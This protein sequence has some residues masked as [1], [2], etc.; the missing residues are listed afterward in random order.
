MSYRSRARLRQN[1]KLKSDSTC[2]LAGL[3]SIGIITGAGPF[4]YSR[5]LRPG[6]FSMA[7]FFC[8]IPLFLA[9]TFANLAAQES[10][11]SSF[12]IS[13]TAKGDTQATAKPIYV[14]LWFDTEDYIL[15]A[16]DDAALRLANFLKAE[17]IRGTFKLVGEK[18]K[19]LK[20]RGRTD[21]IE[22]LKYHDIGYHS[23][24]H[25]IPPSPAMYLNALGFEEGVREFR[26]REGKGRQSVHEVFG[27]W[28]SCYGQPGSSWGP[29][30]YPVLRD[31][32][33]IYLDAGKHVSIDGKPCRMGGVL[34][35]YQLEHTIRADLKTQNGMEEGTA[36]FSA[37]RDKL[38]A[39]GGGIVS[40]VYHPCEFI[41]KEFWDG[42]NFRKGASPDRKD[43]KLP[44]TKTPEEA[45][46]AWRNFEGFVRHMKRFP[47]VRFVTAREISAHYPDIA[48]SRTWERS[49]IA[50][51]ISSMGNDP[52]WVRTNDGA[53][54]PAELFDLAI[55]ASLDRFANIT[56]SHKLRTDLA[57]P[58]TASPN[59][60]EKPF[61]AP[62][63]LV[64]EALVQVGEQ[65]E[66]NGQIPPAVWLGS[67]AISPES[68]F[69]GLR[70]A[71]EKAP[72]K[73][74]FAEG[75]WEFPLA[76]LKAAD[77]IEPDEGRL[78]NWVIFP[79]GFRAPNLMSHA[80]RQA[81]TLKPADL[82]REK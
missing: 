40:I 81:W 65:L 67:T 76:R 23:T 55:K 53:L 21:V 19:V 64:R 33:M 60:L 8:L 34:N 3:G 17:G 15:P 62:A 66:Q 54:S 31:W 73:G 35:L 26:R 48:K 45:A 38:L 11:K 72:V 5:R 59:P 44:S 74:P 27:V 63:Y 58:S 28:P 56:R 32:D 78:W 6:N 2:V 82:V 79:E 42:V 80:R 39:E 20:E 13:K 10:P 7:R 37:A 1:N 71:W 14:L 24:N 25:S 18:A 36:K 46:L 49:Q 51:A 70:K 30:S 57:G 61:M 68:F 47:E 29:Q 43:W 77:A 4:F 22:A 75:D 12:A 9:G 16:S 52:T 50:L 41:H 69:A